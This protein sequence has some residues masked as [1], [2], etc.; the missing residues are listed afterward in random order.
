MP[1]QCPQ[2]SANGVNSALN[3]TDSSLPHASSFSVQQHSSSSGKERSERAAE[4]ELWFA[5]YERGG[6]GGNM[7][8]RRS[9]HEQA[10]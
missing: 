8:Q 1:A 5:N 10:Q 7:I 2:V 4:K 6:K 3:M 9:I